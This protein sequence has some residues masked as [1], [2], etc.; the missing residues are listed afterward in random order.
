VETR[1]VPT[2][3]LAMPFDNAVHDRR[4]MGEIKAITAKHLIEEL[5]RKAVRNRN[6]V[7][8]Y[9][10]TGGE[11]LPITGFVLDEN[12]GILTTTKTGTQDFSR[13]EALEDFEG[14][15]P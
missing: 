15:T 12:D 6:S 4:S 7:N 10:D 11:L 14:A 9:A 13:D 8:L 2:A 3:L 5:S 1:A